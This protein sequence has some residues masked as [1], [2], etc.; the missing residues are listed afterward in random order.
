[1]GA[2]VEDDV[3]R[4]A[5]VVLNLNLLEEGDEADLLDG[6]LVVLRPLVR[7]RGVLVVVEGHARRD[8][9]EQRGAAVRDRSL[10]EREELL[11]VA[12]ERPRHVAAPELDRERAQVHRRQV[13]DDA[14]LQ[15]RAQVRSG[16]ELPLRQTVHAVVLDDVDHREVAAEQVHELARADRGGVAVARHADVEEVRVG[17]GGAGRDRRHPAVHGVEAVSLVH[18]VRRGLGRAADPGHLRDPVRVHAHLV[19]R[20]RDLPRNDVVPAAHAQRGLEAAVLLDGQTAAV[21]GNGFRFGD[22]GHQLFSPASTP[23]MTVSASRGKPS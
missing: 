9:V 1:M 5:G 17:E 16:R 8:H 14:G 13:V 22:G 21:R 7:L 4:G 2:V 10:D 23:S 15:L 6:D 3:L 20:L 19:E 18:E 12:R 11:H